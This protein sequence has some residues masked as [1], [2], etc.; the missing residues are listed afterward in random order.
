MH[1]PA[2]WQR[3]ACRAGID[4]FRSARAD[5]SAAPGSFGEIFPLQRARC[6]CSQVLAGIPPTVGQEAKV[7][8]R[9]PGWEGQGVTI[10]ARSHR[11]VVAI[12][13]MVPQ[14]EW[15]VEAWM[16]E[17]L[18]AIAIAPEDVA[19]RARAISPEVTVWTEKLTEIVQAAVEGGRAAMDMGGRPRGAGE[20]KAGMLG[21]KASL[22]A[23]AEVRAAS[24]EGV[25]EESGMQVHGN[26][27]RLRKPPC[28]QARPSVWS[29]LH[30]PGR[31]G[32][33]DL[34][35]RRV[36]AV[37]CRASSKLVFA[38]TSASRISR[39]AARR[40]GLF[41]VWC[42]RQ[43]KRQRQRQRQRQREL[44]GLLLWLAAARLL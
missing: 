22:I 14:H 8:S 1:M 3:T 2:A 34:I 23:T 41:K 25:M 5:D 43:R 24:R 38:S 4:R 40:T 15:V 27:K 13:T 7:P 44:P 12:S 9:I 39:R 36:A 11:L 16:G 19:G 17:A 26:S 29:I 18:S 10:G 21:G 30:P 32:E 28:R 42:M 31:R 33:S 20:E 35:P 37:P 6:R